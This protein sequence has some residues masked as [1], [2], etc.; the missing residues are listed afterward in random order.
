MEGYAEYAVEYEQ[1]LMYY[2]FNTL[3]GAVYDGD[4]YSKI[5]LT[6]VHTM[7]IQEL[8]LGAWLAK[9][10]EFTFEDQV[11]LVHR[12]AR[13]TE[14]SDLNLDAMECMAAEEESFTLEA[15]LTGIL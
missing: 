4:L 12:Y 3:C 11:E 2:V 5:K 8:D 1:L 7:L 15:L 9:G 10:K 13:E 14:H 6:V